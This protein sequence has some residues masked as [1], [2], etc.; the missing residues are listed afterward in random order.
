L[1]RKNKISR[2]S[3]EVFHGRLSKRKKVGPSKKLAGDVFKNVQVKIAKGEYLGIYEENKI[4]FEDFAKEYKEIKM[5]M[6][7]SHLSP[8]HIQEAMG[9]L[10]SAWSPFGHQRGGKEKAT[11]V[12]H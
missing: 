7:Y 3:W 12:T 2:I 8:G 5:T 4:S 11:H 9:K 10:E 6:R 1:H